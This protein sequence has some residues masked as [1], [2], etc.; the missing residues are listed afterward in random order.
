MLSVN[1]RPTWDRDDELVPIA[2]VQWV[3]KN[4]FLVTVPQYQKRI[5]FELT[6]VDVP[7]TLEKSVTDVLHE[8]LR[9]VNASLRLYLRQDHFSNAAFEGYG[10]VIFSLE[11]RGL[12]GQ[13]LSLR[14][15]SLQEELLRCGVGWIIRPTPIRCQQLLEAEASADAATWCGR[16]RAREK[17]PA[18]RLRG[19]CIVDDVMR[20]D[21]YRVRWLQG[22]AA[23]RAL[24]PVII[25][26][27]VTCFGPLTA[28][29]YR[30]MRWA[31]TNVLHHT[32]EVLVHSVTPCD[33]DLSNNTQLSEFEHMHHA[34]VTAYLAEDAKDLGGVILKTGL[35]YIQRCVD[36][37][38]PRSEN[39]SS[40]LRLVSTL[41][42]AA[43]LGLGV[44]KRSRT[45]L[46]KF[47]SRCRVPVACASTLLEF[48]GEL[49]AARVLRGSASEE[50]AD[51]SKGL[52]VFAWHTYMWCGSMY[53]DPMDE[54]VEFVHR[55]L[56]TIAPLEN[57][58]EAGPQLPGYVTLVTALSANDTTGG[59][60]VRNFLKVEVMTHLAANEWQKCM[61]L[62]GCKS[63]V[64]FS[65]S[66]EEVVYAPTVPLVITFDSLAIESS[67]QVTMQIASKL[68]EGKA[69][70]RSCHTI[71]LE[72]S[73]SVKGTWYETNLSL[74]VKSV[75]HQFL[76]VV[77]VIATV[78]DEVTGAELE[79]ITAQA[80]YSFDPPNANETI[81]GGDGDCLEELLDE[82]NKEMLTHPKA[83]IGTTR[84]LSPVAFFFELKTELT[85]AVLSSPQACQLAASVQS[86]CRHLLYRDVSCLPV[87]VGTVNG[88]RGL[89]GDLRV[90]STSESGGGPA[91]Y[92]SG[93]FL[94]KIGAEW[95]ATGGLTWP[96]STFAEKVQHSVLQQMIQEEVRS[97]G[98]VL[99]QC[100]HAYEAL[101]CFHPTGSSSCHFERRETMDISVPQL[102]RLSAGRCEF[103]QDT[104]SGAH[105][106]PELSS[107][108]FPP[109]V[110]LALFSCFPRYLFAAN[111]SFLQKIGIV[112]DP[113]LR[114]GLFHLDWTI[115]RLSLPK[116]PNLLRAD[117]EKLPVSLR[118]VERAFCDFLM[119]SD[120][121]PRGEAGPTRERLFATES[122]LSDFLSLLF[123]LH[124]KCTLGAEELDAQ[125]SAH[126]QRAYDLFSQ[127]CTNPLDCYFLTN[128]RFTMSLYVINKEQTTSPVA[129]T[130]I[131]VGRKDTFKL[132]VM[133]TTGS[134]EMHH[135]DRMQYPLSKGLL[136]HLLSAVAFEAFTSN[137]LP[138][139]EPYDPLTNCAALTH[140]RDH[141]DRPI[142][143]V[144]MGPFPMT[145]ST[146]RLYHPVP[147]FS[148]LGPP[149]MTRRECSVEEIMQN[150]P[151]KAKV[152]VIKTFGFSYR[153]RLNGKP[154]N[155]YKLASYGQLTR[156]GIQADM[157]ESERKLASARSY[158]SLLLRRYPVG[159]G[160]DGAFPDGMLHMNG[161]V[162]EALFVHYRSRQDLRFS[163]G[164]VSRYLRHLEVHAGGVAG[165]EGRESA[166]AKGEEDL[167]R[168]LTDYA[169]HCICAVVKRV[170]ESS[171]PSPPP[172]HIMVAWGTQFDSTTVDPE[173]TALVYPVDAEYSEQCNP[174]KRNPHQPVN[175]YGAMIRRIPRHKLRVTYDIKRD[176]FAETWEY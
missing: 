127:N 37:G 5:G 159:G 21:V 61:T 85:P 118:N 64:T 157:A 136:P 160:G 70:D 81:I 22:S 48:M 82:E 65:P 33:K 162:S 32:L 110:P 149:L 102:L 29:G 55:P 115:M 155:P 174:Q 79:R 92:L 46:S 10:D 133:E 39:F 86:A 73:A 13:V 146:P 150:E 11:S 141:M 166:K 57:V 19:K 108:A 93:S 106:F 151:E 116:L 114:P 132:D 49:W 131:F 66:P 99:Q 152:N 51:V 40:L 142:Q 126:E 105:N 59:L 173:I 52:T 90:N 44:P 6:A 134:D 76:F 129:N 18:F 98:D 94:S 87:G 175:L 128:K 28:K 164:T 119:R 31:Q 43:R 167:L 15:A 156:A 35:G 71:S 104:Q 83:Q 125:S 153:C 17:S 91:A 58:V 1:G 144:G 38:M 130:V 68:Y 170:T 34:R 112:P 8:V 122:V 9:R 165:E 53:I 124:A 69:F 172:G 23:I 20:G 67:S 111:P 54:P 147:R 45:A 16:C 7:R 2:C 148:V 50:K 24:P 4:S 12:S 138:P 168:K 169:A 120:P 75:G 74:P 88:V 107:I 135:A 161:T 56:R 72:D 14:W 100:S 117:M 27:S 101:A 145:Q 97:R 47:A 25:L 78:L 163:L 103:W 84:F 123:L 139:D 36:A 41:T 95:W 171:L 77:D 137:P 30:A 60:P 154:R 121:P 143:S 113:H 3:A 80:L 26:E 176:D 63:T 109:Y 96:M 89:L 62:F 140:A 42:E 158:F